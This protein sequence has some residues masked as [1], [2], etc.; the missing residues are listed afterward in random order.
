MSLVIGA[1]VAPTR[2]PHASV[3]ADWRG[4]LQERGTRGIG[5][6]L[7]SQLVGNWPPRVPLG[8]ATR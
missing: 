4:E 3:R 8:R 7:G 5:F 6:G 2:S 1:K